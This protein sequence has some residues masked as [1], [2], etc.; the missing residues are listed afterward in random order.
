MADGQRG[1]DRCRRVRGA[2]SH[3]YGHSGVALLLSTNQ[4]LG[5]HGVPPWLC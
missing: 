3:T 1:P 4:R 5:A 2:A